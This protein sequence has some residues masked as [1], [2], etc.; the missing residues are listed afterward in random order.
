[1]FAASKVQPP[2][3][4][5]N[6]VDRPALLER[7]TAA[8]RSAPLVLLSAAA[9][10]G[11]TYLLAQALARLP[12]DIAQAWVRA[13]PHDDVHSIVASLVAALDTV[14]P[15]W[16]MAPEAMQTVLLEPDG[17]R[18]V[19]FELLHGLA[20]T[21]R[22]GG[23]IVFDDLHA[24]QDPHVFELLGTLIGAMPPGWCLAL[25]SRVDPPLR[26]ARLRA[27]G[28]LVEFRP[29]DLCFSADEVRQLIALR[30]GS[31]AQGKAS[32]AAETHVA[33]LL[34]DTG[35][36]VAG[37]C[38][39]LMSHGGSG[40]PPNRRS[41]RRQLFEYL[42]S[43][44]L[45]ELPAELSRFLIRCSV[46]SEWTP[47]RCV[48]L[49]GDARAAAWLEDIERRELFCST[50]DGSELTLRP[51]DLFRSFLQDRL[52]AELADEVPELTRRAAR[53]EPDLVRQV[54]LLLQAGAWV[55]A[56][57]VLSE[58]AATIHSGDKAQVARMLDRFPDTMHSASA[59]LAYM[60][61]LVA[62]PQMHSDTLT[63]CMALAAQ[64]FE[65]RRQLTMADRARAY[66]AI[67]LFYSGRID[68]A[69]GLAEVLH[70]SG[71]SD[72][73]VRALLRMLD[74]VI[75][76]VRGPL[77]QCARHLEQ[78]T[79]ELRAAPPELWFRCLWLLVPAPGLRQ[80]V[81]RLLNEALTVAGEE[82]VYLR[83]SAQMQQVTTLIYEARV[84]EALPLLKALEEDSTWQ[85]GMVQRRLHHLRVLLGQ[86]LGEDVRAVADLVRS[87]LAVKPPRPALVRNAALHYARLCAAGGDWGTV[88]IALQQVDDAG[89]FPE[90]PPVCFSPDALRA[91]LALHEGDAPAARRLL[92]P[93]SVGV[94]ERDRMGHAAFVLVTLA[95][96]H[97]RCG[98]RP[99]AWAALRQAIEH[100]GRSRHLT[101]LV[102][103]GLDQLDELLAATWGSE[104]EPEHL[105]SLR[106]WVHQLRAAASQAQ[107]RTVSRFTMASTPVEAAQACPPSIDTGSS[108]SALSLEGL[109]RREI[110]VLQHLASGDSNKVI[111]R[112]LDLSPN[113]V[114][115]HVA[116][117]L[118]RLGVSS[119]GEAASVYRGTAKRGRPMSG[120]LP[121]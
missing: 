33:R 13:D 47:T 23:V 57:E 39:H 103:A 112:A 85:S 40:N 7:L 20:S 81:D 93:L 109:T 87:G 30:P 32:D 50:I 16:R 2:Q 24:V 102:T 68:E 38:L 15:P 100:V 59:A 3:I 9:G 35:G 89:G 56:E 46:L 115:R 10:Y 28:G 26:L 29:A 67:G 114:K 82:H 36:W 75:T 98:D 107:E 116:R 49:T 105:N 14:D 17:A 48:A 84:Q 55:E 95:V 61:G 113:T 51:L 92:L 22:A 62:L 120:R 97:L 76:F 1:V 78:L 31:E 41:S 83:I 118:S 73:E 117:I 86:V 6:L 53:L 63:S 12:E 71:Q 21:D 106:K 19:A 4:R 77:E 54:E 108:G 58:A 37:L 70:G 11:K 52:L 119:R 91:R 60:R 42:G 5:L 18:R 96:A 88:R 111:A 44:V 72:L 104:A 94:C 25:A 99:A 45:A 65:T 8:L 101:N 80:A 34:A 110:E 74:H 121:R 43:E 64:G 90:G 79:D 69:V 27:Q 66:L